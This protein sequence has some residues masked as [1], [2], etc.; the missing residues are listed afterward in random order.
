MMYAAGA[1]L[2]TFQSNMSIPDR[3]SDG[4]ELELGPSWKD[5][6]NAQSSTITL[7]QQWVEGELH[8]DEYEPGAAEVTLCEAREGGI[9]VTCNPDVNGGMRN[10]PRKVHWEMQGWD[11]AGDASTWDSDSTESGYMFDRARDGYPEWYE[12]SDIKIRCC[13]TNIYG[14][15]GLKPL[16]FC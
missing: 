14:K 8:G 5:L 1:A 16:E 2:P 6:A 10:T 15:T 11:K 12:L 13:V 3:S 4:L 7:L 9:V